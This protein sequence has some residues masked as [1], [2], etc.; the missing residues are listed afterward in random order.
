[1]E[2]GEK[3]DLYTGGTSGKERSS[4]WRTPGVPANP[5]LERHGARAMDVLF[6]IR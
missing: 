1:M 5:L 4:G 6:T 2:D 3:K